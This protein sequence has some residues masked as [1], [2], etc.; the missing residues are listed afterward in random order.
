M[1]KRRWGV[2]S[3][4]RC[5]D[6]IFLLYLQ[7][8]VAAERAN[9]VREAFIKQYGISESRITYDSKGSRVQ[10]FAENDMN[11]VTIAIAE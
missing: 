8:A 10:P 6:M 7:Q 2:D 5:C 1:E 11:R 9:A 4:C 3:R